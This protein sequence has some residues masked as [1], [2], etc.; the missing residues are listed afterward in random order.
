MQGGLELAFMSTTDKEEAMGYARRAPGMILFEIQQGFVARGASIAWLSQYPDEKKYS[1]ASDGARSVRH[2][3]RGRCA[4]CRAAAEHEGA[5]LGEDRF[6]RPR[7]D[8][9]AALRCA[10]RGRRG[11]DARRRGH[12]RAAAATAAKHRQAMWQQQ[13]ADVRI[14]A[15]REQAA[16]AK[17]KL[18]RRMEL[19]I[20]EFAAATTAQKET[21]RTKLKEQDALLA[22]L[23][24]LKDLATSKAEEAVARESKA[25]KEKQSAEDK[26]FATSK[27]LT[28]VTSQA[29]FVRGVLRAKE[30]A[31]LVILERMKAIQEES[32]LV[33]EPEPEAS[34]S[35][36]QSGARAG[37][38]GSLHPQWKQTPSPRRRWITARLTRT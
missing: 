12:K 8:G 10:E 38:E 7:G 37:L 18:A 32:A 2:A 9:T 19:L 36:S 30:A 24:Q 15:S 35:P 20:K 25:L 13:M 26:L 31:M 11:E 34:Q 27:M 1:S 33:E 21:L 29:Q 14:A 17:L 23:R 28:A 22:E 4:H 6:K 5:R 16:G 3:R